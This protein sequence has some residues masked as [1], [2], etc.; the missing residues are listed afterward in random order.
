MDVSCPNGFGF[1]AGCTYSCQNGF[2]LQGSNFTSCE[3]SAASAGWTD[4]YT[5]PICLGN[6][7]LFCD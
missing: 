7:Y 1:G 6:V 3:I 5:Q 2:T 4:H